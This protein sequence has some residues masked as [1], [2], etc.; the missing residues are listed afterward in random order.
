M[1]VDITAVVVVGVASVTSVTLTAGR[2][3]DEG[4]SVI[5]VTLSLEGSDWLPFAEVVVDSTGGVVVGVVSVGSVA[6]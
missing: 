4:A 6:L 2:F 1:V 5:V 3:V